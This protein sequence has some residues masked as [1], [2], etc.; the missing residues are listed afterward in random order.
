MERNGVA[1]QQSKSDHVCLS[2]IQTSMHSEDP[3][4]L[5]AELVGLTL[6]PNDKIQLCSAMA[7]SDDGL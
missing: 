1:L 2:L 3:L 5:A 7:S 4:S 6:L